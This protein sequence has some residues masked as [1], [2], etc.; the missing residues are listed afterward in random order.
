MRGKINQ[1]DTSK[2]TAASNGGHLAYVSTPN[3]IEA[4][5]NWLF[6]IINTE[7]EPSRDGEDRLKKLERIWRTMEPQTVIDL[8]HQLYFAYLGGQEYWL[9]YGV[10]KC[11]L[12]LWVYQEIIYQTRPSLIIETGTDVGG[13]AKFLANICQLIGHGRVIS[14]DVAAS[15]ARPVL[16]NLKYITG[17]SV[18]EKVLRQ[19]RREAKNEKVMVVLD[20]DHSTR[21]VLAEMD[22]YGPL[23]SLGCYMIVEDSNIDGRPIPAPSNCRRGPGLALDKW[24]PKHP[25]FT[26]DK[27]REKFGMTLNPGGFLKRY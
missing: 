18:D 25:E 27:F 20:S 7:P 9:G 5:R 3:H 21:N 15:R 14:I 23:V 8:F 24:V 1:K 6:G 17:R 26:A 2:V 13:S 22:A 10:Q 19:V 12:D 4:V 16:A 11:P